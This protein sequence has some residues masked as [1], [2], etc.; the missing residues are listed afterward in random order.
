MLRRTVVPLSIRNPAV[1]LGG[2]DVTMVILQLD[3]AVDVALVQV[4]PVPQHTLEVEPTGGEPGETAH[5]GDLRVSDP[6]PVQLLSRA[7]KVNT[8]KLSVEH[9]LADNRPRAELRERY[10]AVV[11][12]R[13]R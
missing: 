8:R 10:L 3:R 11:L 12:N 2:G 9:F 1:A 13:L 4:A 6:T 7:L 5:L